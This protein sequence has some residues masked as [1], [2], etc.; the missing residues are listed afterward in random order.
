MAISAGGR[1]PAA[2]GSR[3]FVRACRPLGEGDRI[4]RDVKT[5]I[6]DAG[7]IFVAVA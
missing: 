1:P 6:E 3:Y 5:L 2:T 4:G 7:L